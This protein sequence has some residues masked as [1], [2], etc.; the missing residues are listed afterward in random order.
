MSKHFMPRAPLAAIAIARPSAL[1]GAV[2]MES[3]PANIEALLRDVKSELARIG[4]DVKRTAEDALKQAKDSGTLS[5][6]VKDKADKMLVQQ[7]A[8]DAAQKK[9]EEKLERLET[10]NQDLEQRV[11][12]RR[13]LSVDSDRKT[14]GQHVAE[15]DA[16]KAFSKGGAKGT[17]SIGVQ[18]AITSAN[19]SAGD[20]IAPDRRTEIVGMPRRRMTIRQLLM[21]GTTQ[22]N[23][24]QYAKQVTRT[25]LA[26][27]VTEGAQKPESIYAWD[28]ANAAVITIAHWV[29]VSR[30]ALD[31]AGQLQS[32]ID[33]E[34][35]YGLDLE[36]ENQL[37]LGAGGA[38]NLHGLVPQATA[39]SA[40]F[41][42]D[43][44]TPIDTLRLAMLQASL[45]EYPADGIVLHPT[46]WARIE[47]T[48]TDSGAYLFANPL[49]LAG[50]ILW[51]Q[52]VVATQAMEVDEFLVGAFQMA[53]QIFDR[54][55]AEVA[56][57][58][59][60]RDNFIKNML[61]MRAEKRLA[62]AVKRPA[63]LISGDFGN[64]T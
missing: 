5:A 43:L 50:P 35:R 19:T 2:R 56:I 60:D 11:S 21:P 48:K 15:H 34:L 62:L 59:E 57:S 63:A 14:L 20:L 40:A 55:D 31:D 33:G 32:L 51:G 6:E 26:A 64:V 29:P 9:L 10:R 25:N 58:S 46:D 28:L 36:E 30:Q 8:L 52:P 23:L 47:L 38:E 4:D 17:I 3:Q 37:L 49:G 1:V 54:M 24:I 41:S 45:A 39:Y 18:N 53:A 12:Q 61:T 16:V 7:G 22:S 27:P 42:P 44:A 13:S